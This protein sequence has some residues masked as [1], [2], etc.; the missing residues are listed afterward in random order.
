MRADRRHYPEVHMAVVDADHAQA[1][2]F[3]DVQQVAEI[4]ARKVFARIAIAAFLQWP[5][6]R[7]VCAAFDAE[8]AAG[9]ERRPIARDPG[10]QNAIEHVHTARDQF[11]HLRGSPQTHSITRFV[12]WQKRLRVFDRL[13]HF[14]LWLAD[15]HAADGVSIKTHADNC[16]GALFTDIGMATA[17]NDA[18]HEL[19]F[20]TGLLAAFAGPADSAFDGGAHVAASRG[21]RRAI[22]EDHCDVRPENTLDFHRLLRP[23]KKE[24]AVQMRPELDAVRFDFADV[25]EAEDLKAAAVGKDRQLPIDEL[26]QPA[27]FA[28]DIHPGANEQMIRI[29]E[30][31]LRAGLEQLAGIQRFDAALGADRHEYRRVHD[32]A[33]SCQPAQARFA[34]GVRFQQFEHVWKVNHG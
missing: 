17:L 22:I 16:V 6:I 21:M 9:G 23:K 5:K 10:R 12:L 33:R 13:H 8:C 1:E 20:G 3:A 28:D 25:R 32:A 34:A 7:F 27:G 24:G 4:C 2:N 14:R 18:E 29:A 11:N 31:D 26:M 15:A 19:A 30:N